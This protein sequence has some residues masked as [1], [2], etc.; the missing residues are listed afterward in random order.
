M[1]YMNEIGWRQVCW[2]GGPGSNGSDKSDSG[3]EGVQLEQ[4]QGVIRLHAEKYLAEGLVA[5]LNIIG[6]GTLGDK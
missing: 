6:P 2:L 4:N 3:V 5:G 1:E